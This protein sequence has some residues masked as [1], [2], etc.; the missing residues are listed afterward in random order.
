MRSGR[1]Y[2]PGDN[3]RI[4]PMWPQLR[5]LFDHPAALAEEDTRPTAVTAE[6][7][8]TDGIGKHQAGDLA[9]AV[10]GARAFRVQGRH[11]PAGNQRRGVQGSHGLLRRAAPGC[12]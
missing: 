1:F 6:Q 11:F 9:G 2:Y 5:K 7:C 10:K 3:G 4:H 12:L 8:L